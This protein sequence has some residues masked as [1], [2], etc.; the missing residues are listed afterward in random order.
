MVT[1]SSLS[2]LRWPALLGA[3]ALGGALWL[4]A[5]LDLPQAHSDESDH[6]LARQALQQGK[7]LPL[8]TVLDQVERQYQGQ[9]LKVEF[10]HDDGRFIYEMR[11]LHPNGQ[12][13]K[14]KVD[15]VDGRVL[16]VRRKGQD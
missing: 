15:A 13:S 4:G 12:L 5:G 3:F 6:E 10:E 16:S 8:R 9:V 14:L 1:R 2:R 11:L 7:V